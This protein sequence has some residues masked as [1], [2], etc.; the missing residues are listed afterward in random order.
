MTE[1]KISTTVMLD[2]KLYGIA[3]L[4]AAQT[5]TSV[6]AVCSGAAQKPCQKSVTDQL[7]I[8]QIVMDSIKAQTN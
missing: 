3:I 2:A 7:T 6:E 8:H 5:G 4:L 1:V